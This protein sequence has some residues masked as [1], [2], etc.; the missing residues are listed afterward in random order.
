MA[1]TNVKILLRRGARSEISADTLLTGEM[2]FANDTN[3]VY[4]G[5]DAALD[6]V[7]FDPFANA[8]ATI[9]SWLDN[10]TACKTITVTAGG[11]G[12]SSL[13]TVTISGGAGTGATASA[14][15]TA[16]V[17]TAITISDPGLGYTSAP[18]VTIS[19][20]IATVSAG[21][22]VVSTV[23]TILTLGTT[24][25]AQ[26]NTTAGTSA[27]TY[28]VGDTFTAATVGAGTGTA[29][30]T[31]TGATATST[32]GSLSPEVGL[33][34]NEDLVI[35]NVTDVDGLLTAMSTFSSAF[36]IHSY[37]RARRNVEV[38]T[39]N[40]FNQAFTNMHLE[41]HEAATGK[42]SDLFKK[43]LATTSGTFLKYV[44]TGS[45]SFFIDYSLKQ[46]GASKTFVRVGTL[47]VINGAAILPTPIAQAKLTDENTEI[48]IDTNTD[49]IV[50]SDEVSNIEFT[51]VIDGS[52]VKINYTQDASFTT[53]ISYTVKRWSM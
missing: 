34:I 40:S 49:T 16:G 21:S 33:E 26:W 23:Y 14:T 28:V 41:A 48:W 43:S 53:E 10:T 47:K 45:T 11:T 12:Y 29:T 31:G 19:D 9:Q 13:P 5:I 30:Y 25:Q 22:F 27:I 1:T 42:R 3:Q 39:E 51:A 37:G 46:V 32:I 50:D 38:L 35:G 36:N 7:V 44:K 17:V 6:E 8:H 15:L 24:T 18:T 2:G 20:T 4:I 52:N